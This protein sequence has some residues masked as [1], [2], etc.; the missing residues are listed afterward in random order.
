MIEAGIRLWLPHGQ[1]ANA[2][3]GQNQNRAP[4]LIATNLED[5]VIATIATHDLEEAFGFYRDT[6]GFRVDHFSKDRDYFLAHSGR[7]NETLKVQRTGEARN[8]P[9]EG[10]EPQ[11]A[12]EFPAFDVVS[13]LKKIEGKIEELPE[14]CSEMRP[15]TH[16][17]LGECP[18]GLF[19]NVCDPS[20]NIICF[21]TWG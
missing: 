14:T 2:L 7:E 15:S 12:L 17:G 9:S 4:R 8:E 3:A 6:L 5:K 10:G 16:S 13:V 1:P 21:Y 20:G 11:P 19:I 18:G